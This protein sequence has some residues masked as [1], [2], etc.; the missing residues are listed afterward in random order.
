MA[1]HSSLHYNIFSRKWV[2]TLL[3][4]EFPNCHGEGKTP[5]EARASL[6]IRV[7]QLRAKKKKL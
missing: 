4:G 1:I 7:N 3:G 6:H 2:S 5:D